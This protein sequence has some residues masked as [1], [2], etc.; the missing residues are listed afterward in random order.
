MPMS[1]I[2]VGVSGCLPSASGGIARLACV[3]LTQAEVPLEPLLRQA[4]LILAQIEDRAA[5]VPVRAQIRFLDLAAHALDDDFLG[6]HLA[7]T[8]DLREI[9]LLHYVLASC[10]RLDEAMQRV[11]RYS[12]TVNEGV[13]LKYVERNDVAIMFSYVGVARHSDRHQIEFWITA[14]V[15]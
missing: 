9:G 5:R 1:G 2:Q 4:G 6:F 3:R 13:S 14:A 15:R 10:D 11:A 7:Q 12:T 8:F